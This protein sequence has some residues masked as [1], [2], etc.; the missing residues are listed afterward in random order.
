MTDL[1][2]VREQAGEFQKKAEDLF[3]MAGRIELLRSVKDSKLYVQINGA[4]MALDEVS[5]PLSREMN[6]KLQEDVSELENE[7][8]TM[9]SFYLG[10]QKQ[11]KK[12]KTPSKKK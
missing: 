10:Q 2:K 4:Y 9:L 11:E 8:D 12:A 1:A 6:E 3:N 7:C 5:E